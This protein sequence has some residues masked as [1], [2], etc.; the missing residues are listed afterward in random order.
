M[1]GNHL[2]VVA[3]LG[4]L[5]THVSGALAAYTG[6]TCGDVR[7]GTCPGEPFPGSS[8]TGVSCSASQSVCYPRAAV[9]GSV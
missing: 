9:F 7:A 2:T 1:L 4:L 3:G 8:F 5:F 6:P